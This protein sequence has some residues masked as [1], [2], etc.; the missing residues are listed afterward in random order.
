MINKC[1]VTQGLILKQR[2]PRH[3]RGLINS[4]YLKHS[5]GEIT[6]LA[7]LY[8]LNIT[9]TADNNRNR[10]GCVSRHGR[11]VIQQHAF[12]ISVVGSYDNR[13]SFCKNRISDSTYAFIH[14]LPGLDDCIKNTGMAHH[15]GIG[16]IADN[17]VIL[18]S[19]NS[20]QELI[21]Y[22]ISTHFRLQIVGCYF[23]RMCQYSVLTFKGG[24]IGVV[25][26]EGHMC[27]FLCLGTSQL[28]EA[29]IAEDLSEDI[30]MPNRR[31]CY[32][33]L[34]I[35]IISCK[36]YIF[37][38]KFMSL[39]S[40]EIRISKGMGDLSCSVEPEVEVDHCVAVF[41][42]WKPLDYSRL[43]KLIGLFGS[44]GVLNGLFPVLTDYAFQLSEAVVC[45]LDPVP[46]RVTVHGIVSSD[47]AADLS[48][49]CLLYS[50]LQIFNIF[51]CGPGWSIT[52]I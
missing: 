31:K 44:I 24:L 21:S 48:P 51:C 45:D 35:I 29:V 46:V 5:R 13:A 11:A 12:T 27:V 32:F 39:K 43:D 34:T 41:N 23:R 22:L 20:L 15:I 50:G 9:D 17:H 8:Q 42:S 16:K 47:N 18:A 30:F 19:G 36:A 52:S 28:L 2:P 3:L 38:I 25:K 37:Y 6:K 33:K 4:Q 26:K 10:V 40:L 7:I 1:L 49:A 14:S